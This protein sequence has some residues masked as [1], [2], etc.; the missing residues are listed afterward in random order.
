MDSRLLH[1]NPNTGISY[2]WHEDD[3]QTVVQASMDVEPLI[4]TLA[5]VRSDRD[6]QRQGDGM[7]LAGSIPINIFY[8][9]REKYTDQFNHIDK[10]AFHVACIKWLNDN[11]KFRSR[12][13]RL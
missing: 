4:E 6:G 13:K 5:A 9:L 11:G 10:A 12:T 1:H 2:T 7:E 3:E 8:E